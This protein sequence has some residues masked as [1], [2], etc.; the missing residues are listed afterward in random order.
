MKNLVR[1]YSGIWGLSWLLTLLTPTGI[2]TNLLSVWAPYCNCLAIALR[3]QYFCRWRTTSSC[4][5]S[6]TS[7]SPSYPSLWICASALPS[8]PQAE[9]HH[10]SIKTTRPPPTWDQSDL[11]AANFSQNL[12]LSVIIMFMSHHSITIHSWILFPSVP[13]FLLKVHFEILFFSPFVSTP[14]PTVNCAH[15]NQYNNLTNQ[16]ISSPYWLSDKDTNSFFFPLHSSLPSLFSLLPFHFFLP[17]ALSSHTVF[18]LHYSIARPCATLS[19]HTISDMY[20]AS[21]KF[22]LFALLD[23]FQSL[24]PFQAFVLCL[25]ATLLWLNIS[26]CQKGS[27]D[28]WT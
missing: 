14:W 28:L 7:T 24:L 18:L 2:I 12:L 8:V 27:P 19:L 4:L 9:K 25:I 5:S 22:H 17:F 16:H 6:L 20:T 26:R 21:G 3:M 23:S 13:F 10:F 15:S 1:A 11:N